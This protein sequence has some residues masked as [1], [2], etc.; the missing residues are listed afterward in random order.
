MNYKIILELEKVVF[1]NRNII[2]KNKKGD[3][4]VSYTN[5]KESEYS[6]KNFI[7]YLLAAGA[8]VPPGWLLIKF[9]EK[10]GKRSRVAFKVKHEDLL[11][12]PT[13]ILNLLLL[14]EYY[15]PFE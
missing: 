13:K 15:T 11:K 3:I 9:K 5:I 2:V 8:S 1:T 12:L 14:N 6:R 10:I 4:Y 7:N